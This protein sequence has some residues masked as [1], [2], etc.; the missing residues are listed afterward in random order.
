M[1]EYR[2]GVI[3]AGF[4]GR[5]LASAVVSTPRMT[6]AAVTDIDD[7]AAAGLAV[8]LGAAAV[9]VEALA[10]DPGI[11]LVIVSTPNHTHAGLAALA[12]SSGKTVFVE[13]PLALDAGSLDELATLTAGTPARLIV[14]HILRTAPGIRRLVAAARAGELG[15]I[16]DIEGH[17]TRILD[18]PAGSTS[19]KH[20]KEL[21][22]GELLHEIHELDLLC[23]LGGDIERVTTLSSPVPPGSDEAPFRHTLIA[24]SG[25][26]IGQHVISSADHNPR[27]SLAVSGTLGSIV[28]DLRSGFVTRLEAGVAI[29]RW[30]IFDDPAIN[31]ALIASSAGRA[32]HNRAGAGAPVWMAALAEHEMAEVVRVLD[33]DEESIL[34]VRPDAAVRAALRILE[35][36]RGPSAQGTAQDA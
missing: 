8:P 35:S 12:L 4:Q 7:S 18:I 24:F 29:D 9:S 5:N 25:G 26:A 16:L 10:A 30:P 6:L 31:D 14:G 13:K 23:L 22:G 21:S 19:W 11:D 27:W 2:V 32:Q 1:N 28:A 33:G 15:R 17:R 36:D 3:G 34:L 20:R